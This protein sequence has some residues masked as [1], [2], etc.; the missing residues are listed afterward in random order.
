MAWQDLL[1]R[2]H[3][4]PLMFQLLSYPG[5]LSDRMENQN[6]GGVCTGKRGGG[7]ELGLAA[8]RVYDVLLH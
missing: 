8:A 1:V 4:T 3:H 5:S 2:E 7:D 6:E